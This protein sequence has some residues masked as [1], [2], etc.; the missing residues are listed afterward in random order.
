MEQLDAPATAQPRSDK[1]RRPVHTITNHGRDEG[2]ALDWAAAPGSTSDLRL[3]TGDI[4][5]QI[6]LTTTTPTGFQTQ[7]K[8]FLSHTSSVED[9]QWSPTEATVFASC[10]ADRSLRVWDVR[11]KNRRSVVALEDSHEQDVN[12][13]SWNKSVEYLLVS[14]GDEGGIKVWDLRNFKS[15]WV[16]A[17]AFRL[18]RSFAKT[19]TL[20]LVWFFSQRRCTPIS[21]RTV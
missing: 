5:S 6:Y 17:R 2:F 11:V 9:L 7:P 18:P 10:S 19:H 14:G 12:V 21:R 4:A 16:S 3:L 15:R 1:T 20:K 13:I 8:P